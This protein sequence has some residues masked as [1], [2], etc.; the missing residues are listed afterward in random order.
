M[1][2]GNNGPSQIQQQQPAREPSSNP[3]WSTPQP[4]PLKKE[5][6]DWNSIGG[7]SGNNGSSGNLAGR[8]DGVGPNN[9][10]GND[11]GSQGRGMI[12]GQIGDQGMW[13]KPPPQLQQQPQSQWGNGPSN[14]GHL[15]SHVGPKE[16]GWDDISP[17][18]QRRLI[19]NLP[20]YDD[21][22]S[23]W[24]NAIPSQPQQQ[25]QQPQ[26][27][28]M[29]ANRGM[30]NKMD[31]NPMWNHTGNTNGGGRSVPISNSLHTNNNEILSI[32][33]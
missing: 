3:L 25:Q 14:D 15:G 10:G 2:T 21:G 12:N 28:G 26:Q 6:S 9:W 31:G 1:S 18:A 5:T 22:T 4:H 16:K 8:G 27:R 7:V 24:G 19:P 23:L 29:S 13:N 33:E 32:V 30:P 11:R 17:P 20:N